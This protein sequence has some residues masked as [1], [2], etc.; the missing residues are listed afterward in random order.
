MQYIHIQYYVLSNT[1][2][3]Q[4]YAKLYCVTYIILLFP[5]IFQEKKIKKSQQTWENFRFKSITFF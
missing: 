2:L 3:Y 4:Y 5:T 1:I